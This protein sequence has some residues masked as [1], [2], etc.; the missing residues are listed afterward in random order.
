M[1]NFQIISNNKCSRNDLQ[2]V[3]SEGRI[4]SC[5]YGDFLKCLFTNIP[6]QWVMTWTSRF[7]MHFSSINVVFVFHE[8]SHW[9]F[10]VFTSYSL[11]SVLKRTK[12]H[13]RMIPTETDQVQLS[14]YNLIKSFHRILYIYHFSS[15][16]I[17]SN[18]EYILVDCFVCWL[19]LANSHAKQ[20]LCICATYYIFNWDSFEL[21][22]N[23]LGVLHLCTIYEFL[24][25]SNSLWNIS[26]ILLPWIQ[27]FP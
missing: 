19:P 16:Y 22:R 12:Y 6:A 27:P 26:H 21:R 18:I 1:L 5:N 24:N 10:M 4:I 15:S 7:R 14:L 2:K 9:Y 23:A 13:S 17:E 20:M 25:S 3:S 8:I 11:L